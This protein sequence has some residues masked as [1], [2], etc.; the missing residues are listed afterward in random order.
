MAARTTKPKGYEDVLSDYKACAFDG[1]CG[2]P[3]MWG[4]EIIRQLDE[5]RF[6]ELRKYG[7]VECLIH[8]LQ[9]RWFL[10][11]KKLTRSEAKKKY[12][13]KGEDV[14]GPRGGWKSVTFGDKRFTTKLFKLEQKPYRTTYD[15]TICNGVRF[16]R[17]GNVIGKE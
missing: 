13:P 8:S 17:K 16:D 4:F 6:S 11:T 7:D 10:I 12:G 2:E 15:G 9:S 1:Y 3:V 14:F 5:S